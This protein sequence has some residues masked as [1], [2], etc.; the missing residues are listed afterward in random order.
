MFNNFIGKKNNL[1]ILNA[2]LLCG[3]TVNISKTTEDLIKNLNNTC[4]SSQF[5]TT[6]NDIYLYLSKIADSKKV[7]LSMG[8]RDPDLPLFIELSNESPINK[9]TSLQNAKSKISH[10]TS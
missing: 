3:G 6:F 5:L 8:A 1:L 7:L 9:I 4:G 2:S 10:K